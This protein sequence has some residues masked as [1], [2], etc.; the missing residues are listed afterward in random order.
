MWQ[1]DQ[2]HLVIR[3]QILGDQLLPGWVGSPFHWLSLG[4][5]ACPSNIL[6][7]YVSI[8]HWDVVNSL[9]ILEADKSYYSVTP[10]NG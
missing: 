2:V 10:S 7:P 8:A 1:V 3:I 6:D 4:L 9:S 5:V